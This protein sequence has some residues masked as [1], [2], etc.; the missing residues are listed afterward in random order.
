MIGDS[1]VVGRGGEV[2]RGVV[3]EPSHF[4]FASLS[5][6]TTLL[7]LNSL[8]TLW[9]LRV[10]PLIVAGSSLNGNL[11]SVFCLTPPELQPPP[12]FWIGAVCLCRW[13]SVCTFVKVEISLFCIMGCL[14]ACGVF[15]I[16]TGD[17][18]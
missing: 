6:L 12:T 18:S 2:E 5:T 15:L 11:N 16:L 9:E 17:W 7:S 8:L 13:M 14:Q 1:I 4:R 10:N 3:L